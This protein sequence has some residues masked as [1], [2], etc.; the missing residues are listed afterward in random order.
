MRNHFK[1]SLWNIK[2]FFIWRKRNLGDMNIKGMINARFLRKAFVLNHSLSYEMHGG[3]WGLQMF[4]ELKNKYESSVLHKL[5]DLTGLWKESY[6]FSLSFWKLHPSQA[7]NTSFWLT[8]LSIWEGKW[9]TRP[10]WWCPQFKTVLKLSTKHI[11]SS[12][13]NSWKQRVTF[14][15]EP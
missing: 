4:D 9:K 14:L 15:Q 3:P 13:N 8:H 6:P 11:F 2:H 1:W 5:L 7:G 12:R 10:L